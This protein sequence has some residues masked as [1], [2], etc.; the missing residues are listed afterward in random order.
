MNCINVL[1]HMGEVRR[2]VGTLLVMDID[3]K[4]NVK[5]TDRYTD[6]HN[7][8]KTYHMSMSDVDN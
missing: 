1:K 6:K 5:N 7:I 2:C 8:I 3:A 4:K